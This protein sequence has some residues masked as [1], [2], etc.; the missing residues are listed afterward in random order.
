M[1]WTGGATRTTGTI[2]TAAFWNNHMGASGDLDIL[3]DGAKIEVGLIAETSLLEST[4]APQVGK[5]LTYNPGT[6][7]FTWRAPHL[8]R[9]LMGGIHNN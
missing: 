9:N 3:F 1:A 5:T 6:G 8:N 2:I 7:G 4:G